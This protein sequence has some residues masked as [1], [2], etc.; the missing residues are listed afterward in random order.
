CFVSIEGDEKALPPLV[1][2]IGADV[3]IWASD[4]PHFDGHFPGAVTEA[5]EGMAALPEPVV[6]K[7][8]GEN[9]ARMYGLPLRRVRTRGSL[10]RG[11]GSYGPPLDEDAHLAR[12]H[13]DRVAHAQAQ[14][15]VALPADVDGQEHAERLRVDAHL[16]HRPRRVHVR[17]P[18]LE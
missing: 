14:L 3:L 8:L 16:H 10:A 9:A 15:R 5:L 13:E 4:F 11:R 6:R 7:V 2:L 1:D 17:H 18:G 12:R